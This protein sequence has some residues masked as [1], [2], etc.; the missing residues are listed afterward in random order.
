MRQSLLLLSYSCPVIADGKNTNNIGISSG[1]H[2]KV[3]CLGRPR[4]V[5]LRGLSRALSKR[6]FTAVRDVLGA[7]SGPVG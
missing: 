6:R 5:L 4:H 3:G 2:L 7:F 1:F